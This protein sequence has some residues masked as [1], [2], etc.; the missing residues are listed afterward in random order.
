LRGDDRGYFIWL[1][2]GNEKP[3]H[4]FPQFISGSKPVA[5]MKTNTKPKV[6]PVYNNEGIRAHNISPEKALRRSVLSC[7]L[8]EKE[9]YQDG[10]SV[11]DRIVQLVPKVKPQVVAD[12]A[13]EARSKFHLRHVPLFLVRQMAKHEKHKELVAQTLERVIQRADELAEFVAIYWKDKK[14][15]LSAQVKKGLAA[16]F[17]K[18][19]EYSLSKY[20][21]DGAVKLRDVLFLCHA[22]PA[23]KAQEKLWKKL[24]GGKLAEARTWENELSE[25]GGKDKKGSWTA[26]LKE[27]ALGGMALLRNLRNISGAKV[28]R[29]H[30]E[31]AMDEADFHRV[32]P[33]RFI[34]A[35][36]ACPGMED[37]IEPVMLKAL[38]LRRKLKGT[39]LLLVDCSPSMFDNKLSDKS[40][41][42]RADAGLGLAVLVREVCEKAAIVAFSN[43]VA[44]VPPRRGFALAD[45]IKTAVASNG[46]L[47][48]RAVASVSGKY[49]RLIVITDEES[50]DPVGNPDKGR[51]AYMVNVASGKH[52]VGY[53]PWTHIDGFSEAILDFIYEIESEG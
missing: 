27:G 25:K 44:V 10:E 6:S 52:G 28:E 40:D 53:G 18:F 41:L 37:L 15:P 32:L 5:I 13:F 33:F 43:T 26:L 4:L 42:V 21:R 20:N 17:A 47:L 24:V 14:Q 29:K 30:I 1:L 11:A 16:A 9:F 36:R 23:N 50:Q 38:E 7:L 48:G 31:K 2:T 35:A 3:H 8:F 46:T 45:A 22:K 34:A 39:T 49:D 12:L 51:H 19:D